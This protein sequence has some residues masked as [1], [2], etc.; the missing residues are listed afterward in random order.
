MKKALFLDRDGIV[1]IDHGYVHQSKDFEFV[2]SIFPLCK[3]FEDNGFIIIIVTNQSGIGRGFYSEEQFVQLNKWMVGQF[4]NRGITIT[5]TFYC[6]HHPREANGQ[7][8][9]VCQCR[10]PNPGMFIEAQTKHNIDMPNSVMIGDRMSD[11]HAS[12][13]AGVG[14][15]FLLQNASHK[16][17]G[18]VSFQSI[19]HLEDAAALFFEAG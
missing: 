10:K 9:A 4:N 1:N 12:H 11:I 18:S 15:R 6:P 7:Y 8:L 13:N 3:R 2:E 5:D 16:A 17:D 14:H 19:A